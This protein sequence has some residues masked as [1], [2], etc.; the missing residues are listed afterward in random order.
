MPNG[1]DEKTWTMK[2]SFRFGPGA[3]AEARISVHLPHGKIY[4]K[5]TLIPVVVV[6]TSGCPDGHHR[7]DK[8]LSKEPFKR[9]SSV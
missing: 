9:D 6:S 5:N 4:I 2:L 7:K 3:K 8:M 1:E